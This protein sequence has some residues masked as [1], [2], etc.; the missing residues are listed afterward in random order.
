MSL[1]VGEAIQEGVERTLARNGLLFAAA[2]FL[3]NLVTAFM[4]MRGSTPAQ[5]ATG[6]PLAAVPGNAVTAAVIGVVMSLASLAISIAALR[7][8]VTDETEA[9]PDA[10]WKEDIGSALLHTVVGGVIFGAVVAVGFL[11]FVVPGVYLMLSLFFWTLYVAVEDESFYEAFQSTW[12]LT[13]G[14]KWQLLALIIG[15]VA[16]NIVLGL[17]G[18]A[19]SFVFPRIAGL[20]V[21][22]ALSAIGGVF[23]LAVQARAYTQLA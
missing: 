15:I 2:F 16:V 8:F 11:L 13:K 22:Q 4:G 10:A 1:A 3:L 12:E 18:M 19:T 23:A 9:V 20:L 7:V 6:A 21:M 17:V 14:H 5:A